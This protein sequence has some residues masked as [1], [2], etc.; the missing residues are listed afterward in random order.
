MQAR[1]MVCEYQGSVCV[2]LPS[3]RMKQAQTFHVALGIQ[4]RSEVLYWW[5]L[6]P[7]HESFKF[8]PISLSVPHALSPFK[9]TIESSWSCGPCSLRVSDLRCLIC[10][11]LPR[12][13][14]FIFAPRF[15]RKTAS[16][17]VALYEE[18]PACVSSLKLLPLPT[19]HTGLH[20]TADPPRLFHALASACSAP[21]HWPGCLPFLPVILT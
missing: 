10:R 16:S 4:L 8:H 17:P 11:H 19:L 2:H 18:V 5:S 1:L 12:P 9:A 6:F 14:V 3:T 21:S 20:G 13:S 7:S 15:L